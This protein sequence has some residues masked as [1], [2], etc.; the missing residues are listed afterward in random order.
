MRPGVRAGS[1]R[2]AAQPGRDVAAA[3]AK[4]VAVGRVH[5]AR[6]R[7]PARAL[8]HRAAVEPGRAVVAVEVRLEA[9]EGRE[10]AGRPFPHLAPAEG[11]AGLALRQHPLGLGGQAAARPAAPGLGLQGADEGHGQAGARPGLQLLVPRRALLLAPGPAGL[12]PP[13]PFGVAV[14]QEGQELVPSQRLRVDVE[15]RHAFVAVAELVVEGEA[16]RGGGAAELELVA[17]DAQRGGWCRQRPRLPARIGHGQAQAQRHVQRGLVVHVLVQQRQAE[18]VERVVAV[19]GRVGQQGQ[20]GLELLR[21][22][23]LRRGRV[24]QR[25]RPARGVRHGAR[26]VQRVRIGPHGRAARPA[27]VGARALAPGGEARCPPALEPADVAQL[28]QR[29]VELGAL[30]HAQPGQ[31]LLDGRK[32][33][34]R[35][36]AAGAQQRCQRGAVAVARGPGR[37][38]GGL[39]IGLW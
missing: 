13:A 12:A 38:A 24:G 9:R 33:G 3:G 32:A 14:L 28:P 31:R 20:G 15:G 17:L 34:Q 26:V 29:R 2:H 25:Q 1:G 16:G 37:R 10:G 35:V 7:E 5:Q 19:V 27:G 30:R 11:A 4:E 18:G 36:G 39:R 22:L 6:L 23:G 21:E 8:E